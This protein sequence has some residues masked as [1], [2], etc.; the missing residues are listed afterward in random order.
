MADYRPLDASS[1]QHDHDISLTDFRRE[2]QDEIAADTDETSRVTQHGLKIPEPLTR[3]VS[4]DANSLLENDA[5]AAPRCRTRKPRSLLKYWWKEFV[6]CFLIVAAVAATIGTLYPYQGKP[7]PQWPY[8][9]KVNALLSAYM[10]VLKAAA[11]FLLAEGIA[12]QKWRWFDQSP[13]PLYDYAIHDDATRGPF[14]AVLL[15]CRVPIRHLWHWLGCLMILLAL[16][17]DPFTQQVLHY[18]ECNV[19]DQNGVASIPRSNVFYGNGTHIGAGQNSITSE[20]Q[21]A[22]E[23]GI[24][25]PGG[26]VDFQC[27]SGNCTIGT[28]DTIGYCS[29]CTDVSS[30]ITVQMKNS[31]DNRTNTQHL[32]IN[33]SIAGLSNNFTSQKLGSY[34][35]SDFSA[36]GVTNPNTYQFLVGL[37][38]QS[39]VFPEPGPWDPSGS[40]PLNC[41]DAATNNTWRCNGLGAA[42]CTL[43]P[44]VKTYNT[45]VLK[46]T[47]HESLIA[48]SSSFDQTFGRSDDNLE[49]STLKKSCLLPSELQFLTNTLNYTAADDWIPYSLSGTL[50][51]DDPIPTSRSNSSALNDFEHAIKSRGC[52]F[53][54]YSIFEQS[55]A[56]SYTSSAWSGSLV[57]YRNAY[58][59]IA[60]FSGPQILQTLY[61]YGD[62]G[63]ER[64]EEVFKNISES[65]T[66]HMR[67]HAEEE[68]GQGAYNLT[69]A[70]TGQVFVD[71][72]CLQVEWGWLSLAGV[73][74]VLTLVF[75]AGTM[76][77]QGNVTDEVRTWR[78]SAL[79]LVF[80]GPKRGAFDEKEA[81]G[82]RAQNLEELEKRA[83]S[84]K[85]KFEV[86]SDGGKYLTECHDH[87]SYS[88]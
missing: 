72:T 12:Q 38:S 66:R 11:T 20:E 25:A 48:E 5:K 67:M 37:S 86:G 32:N 75:F 43:Y 23:A 81:G 24:V 88:S 50:S 35:S 3:K 26:Q 17:V 78:S 21:A 82:W 58:G 52:L 56:M 57:G 45:I 53:S 68:S 65:F 16:F 49:L 64:T 69:K 47:L 30:Q 31:T 6:A 70:K 2:S 15:L 9:I 14:G 36:F 41:N 60:R 10:V 7:L 83:K 87:G 1:N 4:S 33:T 84:T 46:G 77:D 80:Y 59:G 73:L 55:L 42:N 63:F 40:N 8:A 85:V 34:G 19:L 79:P 71:K 18:S 13:Q 22:L 54:I 39:D 51:T 61:N 27:S 44:C 74:V 29:R 62:F 76:I 28:F